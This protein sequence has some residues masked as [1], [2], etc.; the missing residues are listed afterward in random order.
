MEVCV[1]DLLVEEKSRMVGFCGDMDEHL[2]YH[3]RECDIISCS[4]GL[5]NSVAHF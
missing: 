3:T 5:L 4:T 2:M 1:L